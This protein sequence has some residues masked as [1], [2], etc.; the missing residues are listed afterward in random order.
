MQP[1]EEKSRALSREQQ[2]RRWIPLLPARP[3]TLR[4]PRL[5]HPGF[6]LAAL[7]LAWENRPHGVP[8][9]GVGNR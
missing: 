4:P 2:T 1:E 6:A 5:H 8:G 3:G 9:G 7:S